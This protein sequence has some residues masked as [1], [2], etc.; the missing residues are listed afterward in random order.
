M[1]KKLLNKYRSLPV[2]VRAAF[3]FTICNFML[4]GI[5][6][7]CMPIYTR[8]LPEEEYGTMTLI[9]SYETIF[10]IITTLELYNGAYNRGI[11]KFKE[12]VKTFEQTIVFLSNFLSLIWFVIVM[13]L[14]KPFTDFTGISLGMF[15]IMTGYFITRTAYNCW[16]NKK[17]FEYNYKAAVTI[18]LLMAFISN[19][20]PIITLKIFGAT[21]SVKII[22]TLVIQ[23]LFAL[24]FWVKNFD[25]KNL[26]AKKADI[27]KYLS[28][29]LK[30]QLPLIFHSISYYILGQSD[31]IMIEKQTHDKTNVAFYSVA[32]S[33]AS[34]IIIF[35]N[36][37]N[38]V[39][40][41]W[42][43]Q[44]LDKDQFADVRRIS[45]IILVVVGAVISIFMMLLPEVFK[46][47]FE[48]NYYEALEIVPAVTASV[49]F[50]FLYT[51]FVDIQSFY[52]KTTYIAYAS[53]ICAAINIALNYFGIKIFGY[54]ACAYTTLIC[55]VLMSLLH[56][57]FMRIT[58]KKEN[59][60]EKP[61]NS[62]FIWGFSIILLAFFIFVDLIYDYVIVRYGILV[63]IMAAMFIFR[64]KLMAAWKQIKSK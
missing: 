20:A 16:L 53:T 13:L 30:Y 1:I 41:P 28:F 64:K 44:K 57:V 10:T 61:V 56:Y 52:G 9:T 55:Y 31:K 2:T 33:F 54:F 15:A 19:L 51:L 12:D 18:T 39:I 26:L 38:Q 23:I 45:N 36:S 8:F 35:Q 47:A 25:F 49:Y 37:L 17:R 29:A 24:P 46:L 59:V 3:W 58:C 40:K 14:N 34:V 22:S 50:M 21:A 60:T 11:L 62:A 27:K 7:V 32:Y 5:S 42:R 6:F 43:F 63:V 4:K 48:P